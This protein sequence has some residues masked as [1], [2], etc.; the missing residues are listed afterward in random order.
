MDKVAEFQGKYRFLSNFWIE[1]D[2]TC[3]EI[4]YQRSKC[5]LDSDR[6]LFNFTM[7]P[8]AAKRIGRTVKLLDDWEEIKVGVM[9]ELVYRKFMDHAVLARQLLATGEAELVEGN[10]WGDRFW[11]VD[12]IS[13]K[14]SNELGKILMQIREELR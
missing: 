3:V 5:M 4:E 8:G 12:A 9:R 6:K 10:R 11:G 1:P 2:G 13:G 7:T 14:G